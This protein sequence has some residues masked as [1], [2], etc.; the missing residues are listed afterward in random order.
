VTATLGGVLEHLDILRVLV[1]PA[2][3]DVQISGVVV[4]DP[5]DPPRIEAGDFVL[6]VGVDP[7]R[8]DAVEL[9]AAAAGSAAGVV[10]KA[11]SDAVAIELVTAA[12]ESGVALLI[13]DRDVAW[14][15]LYTLL[16][17]AI[18][19]LGTTAGLGPGGGA[20]GDLF[21]L[22][23]A[24]A[25]M[26]GGPVTI[27]NPESTVLAYSSLDEPIDEPRRETILGRRVPAGW[28]KRL[29]DDGVF[30]RLW[31]NDDVVRLDYPEL[32]DLSTRLAIAVRAG[33]QILGSIWVAEGRAPLGPGAET[34]LRE[35]ARIAALH[36]VRYQLGDDLDRRRSSEQLRAVLEGR[37]PPAMLGEL[38]D[39]DHAPFITVMA[40]KMHD[41]GPADLAIQAERVVSLIELYAQ[42]YRH[43]AVCTGIGRVV[44]MMVTNL[45][46]PDSVRLRRLATAIV[47][48]SHESLHV[49]VHAGIGGTVTSVEAVPV[50]R[51]EADL[52]LRGLAEQ[53]QPVTVA[54]LEDVNP[55]VVLLRLRDIAADEPA[56][57]AG[58][59]D[60]LAALDAKGQTS[61]LPTLRAFLDALGDIPAAA[62]SFGV[63]PNTY[64]Y[65]LRRLIDLADLDIAN[66][67]ERLVLHLQLHLRPDASG[68]RDG[69]DDGPRQQ[70]LPG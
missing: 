61:Y 17:T 59:L 4:H 12:K 32:S 36:L 40:F 2:G 9:L 66:P 70:T 14:G 31:T 11:A 5:V 18:A 10:L 41:A 64:R 50:S 33:G 55:Q 38:L 13:A 1:A 39:A 45:S 16:R 6:A 69:D 26:V 49:N 53:G 7:D 19:S 57:L 30:Q 29:Q 54:T 15:Q 20:V 23:N 52:V 27:E 8:H 48:Q 34:A 25:A 21:T 24:V 22:A 56:L 3:L 47:E 68:P 44:Y 35:A 46:A 51:G 37:R 62:A 28:L 43:Q 67:M 65:R 63:H 58:K 42:A 60:V